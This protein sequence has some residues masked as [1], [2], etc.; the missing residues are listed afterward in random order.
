MPATLSS[1]GP[2]LKETSPKESYGDAM[3][4][5]CTIKGQKKWCVYAADGKKRLGV[6]DTRDKALRQLAAIE[7]SKKAK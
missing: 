7:A 6:H 3:I 5:P 1:L 4:R 2:V